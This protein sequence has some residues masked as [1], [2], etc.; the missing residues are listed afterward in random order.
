[1][2]KIPRFETCG[3]TSLWRWSGS[4]A[5]SSWWRCASPGWWLGR[6]GWLGLGLVLLGALTGPPQ[7][8]AAQADRRQLEVQVNLPYAV[9]F[10]FGSYDVGGLS[11]NVFRVPVPHT[12]AL[13]P[14]AEAWRLVLTGYPG[15]GHFAFET[16]VFGPK[17][18]A[19]EDLV[20]VLPQAELQM[21][22]RRGWTVKPYVAAGLGWTFNGSVASEGQPGG[23]LHVD[24]GF[25]A[26]YAAGISNLFEVPVQD[27]LLSFGTKLAGA[28]AIGQSGGQGFGTLQNSL[29]VR[30]PLRFRVKGF[31]PRPRGLLGALLLLP[32][33]QVLAPRSAS[34]RR[35][36]SV[37]VRGQRRRR[38]AGHAVDLR[39]PADRRQ[40][41]LRGRSDGHQSELRLSVLTGRCRAV[42]PGGRHRDDV[43][44]LAQWPQ[45]RRH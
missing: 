21:P 17:I 8:A 15:Y 13:G 39:E 32:V 45:E 30:H 24:E 37:R 28:V 4:S 29:E 27:F 18:T 2:A 31:G 26:L 22:L 25:L 40:L 12:F 34:A 33:G 23:Q 14:E 43:Q 42:F 3:R 44:S 1:M 20:F 5:A 16:R 36:P 38:Q 7:D 41:R 6:G 9:Q 35:L 10:G 11:V 19:S